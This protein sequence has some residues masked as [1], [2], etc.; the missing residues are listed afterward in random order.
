MQWKAKV[1]FLNKVSEADKR[2]ARENSQAQ[3]AFYKQLVAQQQETFGKYTKIYDSLNAQLMPIFKAGIDQF[4][5]TPQQEATL[6]TAATNYTADAFKD[7]QVALEN[8]MVARGGGESLLPSGAQ[9]QLRQQLG[10]RQAQTEALQQLG[11]TQTGFD[12]GRQNYLTALSGLQGGLAYANPNAF[13]GSANGAAGNATD[14]IKLSADL[15]QTFN[16]GGL[17]GGI[18]GVGLSALTGGMGGASFGSF[19]KA[20]TG[21]PSGAGGVSSLFGGPMTA[22]TTSSPIPF[23]L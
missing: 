21:A 4:G 10:V 20:A 13:A 14:A 6:R 3:T 23:K 11:I 12:L 16:W 2:A 22:S 1:K 19:A 8:A 18:A 17:L 5:F 9:E 15:N 7:Q